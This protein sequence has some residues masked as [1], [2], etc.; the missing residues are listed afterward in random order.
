MSLAPQPS[1]QWCDKKMS[2]LVETATSSK[3]N[4][5]AGALGGDITRNHSQ[6]FLEKLRLWTLVDN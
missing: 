3:D 1:N 5:H 2:P 4:E 6:C